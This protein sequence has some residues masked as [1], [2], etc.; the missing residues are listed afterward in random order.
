[1]L[2]LNA[3]WNFLPSQARKYIQWYVCDVWPLD[4][5]GLEDLCKALPYLHA[6]D[7]FL[8]YSSNASSELS[9]AFQLYT[10]LITQSGPIIL[11]ESGLPIKQCSFYNGGNELSHHLSLWNAHLTSCLTNNVEPM[12]LAVSHEQCLS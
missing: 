9:C 3:R 1:M 5:S 2:S 6:L 7:P 12:K 4:A 11:P 8:Q 10:H